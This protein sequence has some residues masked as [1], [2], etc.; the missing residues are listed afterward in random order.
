MAYGANLGDCSGY[1]KTGVCVPPPF[2]WGHL[3]EGC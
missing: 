2:L 1:S 3:G